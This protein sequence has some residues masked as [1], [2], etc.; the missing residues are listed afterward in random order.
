VG[1]RVV[2]RRIVGVRGNRPLFTDVLGELVEYGETG[3]A[4][5]SRRGLERIAHDAVQAAKRVPR[6]PRE[7]TE[8]ERVANAVWPAPVQERLGEWTLRAAD[9]WTGRANSAL[10]LGDPGL[11]REA[12]IDAVADWYRLKGLPA[13]FNVPLPVCAALDA[14]LTARGWTRSVPTLTLTARLPAVLAAARARADLP[15][16]H[17]DPVPDEAWLAVVAARKGALPA[18]AHH[19]LTAAPV[20]AF[21]SVERDQAVAR[22]AMAGGFLHLGLLEVAAGARRRGLAQHVTR[23]LAEWGVEHGAGTA[24]LQVESTNAAAVALYGR[25]GFTVHH[26]YVT[27]ASGGPPGAAST[28]GSARSA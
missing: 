16:V 14:A 2:V 26:E 9:G 24:F 15:P 5:Q 13:R 7:I 18:A 12:A 4:V 6:S 27:R 1:Y 3:L 20:V 22:G 28:T 23:A 19:V 25:L 17:L 21:A 10:P 11:D 8:L